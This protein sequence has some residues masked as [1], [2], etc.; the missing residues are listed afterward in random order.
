MTAVGPPPCAI[1]T[2]PVS[3]AICTLFLR[4]GCSWRASRLVGS[5]RKGRRAARLVQRRHLPEE[6]DQRLH[7]PLVEA[8]LG[9]HQVRVRLCRLHE[10]VVARPHLLRVLLD[11]G[12]HRAPPLADV[13]AK[14]ADETDVIRG[15][16][17]ELQVDEVADAP[18][19]EDH[20]PFE[21]DQLARLDQDRVVPAAVVDEVVLRHAD[22]GSRLQRR[23]LLAQELAVERVGMVEIEPRDRLVGHVLGGAVVVVL[24]HQRIVAHDLRDPRDDCRLARPRAARDADDANSV[25]LIPRRL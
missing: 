17:V 20:D 10:L 25:H 23:Q 5:V 16:D 14:P 9:D 11:D 24:G 22:G 19:E 2:L 1:R 15:V 18:I 13:A 21:D 3:F 12:V 4:W 6:R 7:G 8:A